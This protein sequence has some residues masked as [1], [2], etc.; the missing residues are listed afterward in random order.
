M[1]TV[2]WTIRH[3]FSTCV[4]GTGFHKGFKR[5]F[6][7]FIPFIYIGMR[8]LLFI[9]TNDHRLRIGSEGIKDDRITSFKKFIEEI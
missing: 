7:L 6:D 1:Q 4:N 2:E 9:V 8:K 5:N 3:D